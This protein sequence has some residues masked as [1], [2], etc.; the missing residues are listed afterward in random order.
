MKNF[1]LA[2]ILIS[3]ASFSHAQF[4]IDYQGVKPKAHE[5][6]RHTPDGYNLLAGK[7]FGLIEQIGEGNAESINSFGD[8]FGLDEALTMIMPGS[9]FAYV[10]STIPA[11]PNVS[12]QALGDDWLSVLARMG[13][14]HG[15]RFV[16]DWDQSLIQ[17]SQSD[18]F[19]KPDYNDPISITDPKSG[20][21]VFIY[22]DD[23][24]VQGH[25]L[26]DGEYIPIVTK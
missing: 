10:D 18:G 16:V 22:T 24:N 12:W 26:V 23:S 20:R 13:K 6:K 25:L 4:F 8:D 21:E 15:L 17:I 11:L 5:T 1:V 3:V 14:E 19:I 9:W 7:Y 2:G